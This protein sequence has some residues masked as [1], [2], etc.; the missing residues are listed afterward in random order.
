MMSPHP[1]ARSRNGDSAMTPVSMMTA[2]GVWAARL[3][4]SPSFWIEA[5]DET[6]P[7]WLP[8]VGPL[9]NGP[10]ALKE[11]H[12]APPIARPPPAPDAKTL[13]PLRIFSSPSIIPFILEAGINVS[14][15]PILHAVVY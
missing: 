4:F 15:L 7:S 9:T 12:L 14:Q 2:I 11:A 8:A 6:T 13:F 10:P 5:R 3:T 1:D